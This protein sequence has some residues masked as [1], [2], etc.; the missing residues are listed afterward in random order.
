MPLPP[1]PVCLLCLFC[2]F[3]LIVNPDWDS[4][5]YQDDINHYFYLGFLLITHL[6]ISKGWTAGWADQLLGESGGAI[7]RSYGEYKVV[8]PQV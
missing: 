4:G 8:A 2:F 3:Y 7:Q 5:C 1:I 6:L